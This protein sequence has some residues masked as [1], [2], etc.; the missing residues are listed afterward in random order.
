MLPAFNEQYGERPT[1]S[2]ARPR[3]RPVTVL[4]S[5][6]VAALAVYVAAGIVPGVGLEGPGGAFSSR[7]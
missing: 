4:L 5:W 3:L 7:H 2:P 1:W 6:L